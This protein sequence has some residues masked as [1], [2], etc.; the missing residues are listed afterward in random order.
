MPEGDARSMSRTAL[1][2]AD[3]GRRLGMGYIKRCLA[4]AAAVA[5]LVDAAQ[6]GREYRTAARR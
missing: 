1:I 3:G 5:G 6:G 4:L 2:R